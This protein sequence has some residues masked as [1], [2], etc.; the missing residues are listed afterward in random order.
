[1]TSIVDSNENIVYTAESKELVVYKATAARMTTS[2]LTSVMQEGTGIKLQLDN[3]P[4]AGK[5]GTTND[6]KD[7]WFVGYTRY[8]TT[9][10]WVGCDMPKVVKELT[11]SSYPGRIWQSFMNELHQDLPAL[12]FLPYAQLSDEFQESQ[13]QQR[14]DA[15]DRRDDTGARQEEGT[16]EDAD[17][18]EEGAE[19]QPEG[20]EE[21]PG[22]VQMQPEGADAQ[23]EDQGADAGEQPTP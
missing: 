6:Y 20:A 9:S 13:E 21:Q 1:V 5:T 2:V 3:M 8:Y 15:Q 22:D 14:Q 19:A 18:Q 7:G 10:V 17:A 11:G 4:S 12:D 23:E 16:P